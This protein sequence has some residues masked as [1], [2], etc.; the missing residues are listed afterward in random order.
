MAVRQAFRLGTVLRYKQQAEERV[1]G[2][3]ARLT[4][5]LAAAEARLAHRRAEHARGLQALQQ[6]QQRGVSAAELQMYSAYLQQLAHDIAAQTHAI[7]DLRRAVEQARGRLEQAMK[8]RK[9][10]ETLRDKATLAQQRQLL[11]EE[12]RC[13][14]ETALRRF[15]L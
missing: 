6:R 14:A 3:L 5:E 15:S 9:M 7:A 13:M 4:H 2:E 8:E 11:K 1:Q 12:E 10:L